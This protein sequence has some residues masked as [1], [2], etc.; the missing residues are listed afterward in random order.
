MPEIR[1]PRLLLAGLFGGL[2]IGGAVGAVL[3][4]GP[5]VSSAPDDQPSGTYSASSGCYDGGQE[6]TGWL[7]VAANGKT[8]MVSFNSTIIHPP[9]T[10]IDLNVFQRPTGMSEIA[11]T[12]NA[13][14][15]E[16]SRSN[17]DCRMATTVNVATG[18]SEPVFDISVNGRI[19]RSIDQD[20]TAANLYFLPNPL[21]AT[22]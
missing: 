9:G 15:T 16:Q 1:G 20:E 12:T 22:E 2:I 10:E 6:N 18:L 8:W 7:Y 17:D 13:T 14:A 19:V 4:P 11:L 3:A 5:L 21:N